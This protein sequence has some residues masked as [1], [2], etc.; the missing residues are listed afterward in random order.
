MKYLPL[1]LPLL[2]SAALAAARET[3]FDPSFLGR[4]APAALAPPSVGQPPWLTG[5]LEDVYLD[6]E[7]DVDLDSI[8][9][10]DYAQEDLGDPLGVFADHSAGMVDPHAALADP[11]AS[12]TEAAEVVAPVPRSSASNGR[13]VSELVAQR[14][15]LA[16]SLVRVRGQIV[17]L[18]EGIRGKTY[19]HL[20]DGSGSAGAGDQDLTVT[21]GEPFELGEVVEVEGQLALDRDLGLGYRYV[22]LL[23][24]ARRIDTR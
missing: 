16:G 11:H 18:T 2:G 15:A 19:L 5:A 22:V 10:C 1:L 13:S 9:A 24:E 12:L 6:E 14:A 4:S 8:A 7:V 17:K 3:P 20:R 21:T 23:E